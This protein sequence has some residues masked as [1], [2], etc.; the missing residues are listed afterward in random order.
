MLHTT[1]T[2]LSLYFSVR[3]RALASF[4]IP[5]IS[6]LANT[7]LGYF[8]DNTSIRKNVRSKVSYIFIMTGIG[9][10]WIGFLVTQIRFIN[11]PPA[12]IDWLD[13]HRFAGP[14]TLYVIY[15][16]FYFLIQNELYW[17]ISTLAREPKELIRLSSF[18]RGLESAGESH[19]IERS[20]RALLTST[21]AFVRLCLRL[22]YLGSQD[23]PQDDP[24]R[25]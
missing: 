10:I 8:L 11:T 24:S 21:V 7:A 4:V 22:R 14:W 13:G 6:L 1:G 9:A 20:S 5:I 3:A 19:S 12:K 2:Y 16:T 25:Q 18:L 15:Y 23:S 17:I